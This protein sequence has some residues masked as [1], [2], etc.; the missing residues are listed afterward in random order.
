MGK[1]ENNNYQSQNSTIKIFFQILFML[2]MTVII[3]LFLGG[4][5]LALRSPDL[6]FGEKVFK[7]WKT[8]VIYSTLAILLTPIQIVTLYIKLYFTDLTLKAYPE[9]KMLLEKRARL[10]FELKS[11]VKLELGTESLYQ[12]IGQ[13]IFLL[14]AKTDTPTDL[15]SDTIRKIQSDSDLIELLVLSLIWSFATNILSN[16]QGLSTRRVFFPFLSQIMAGLYTLCLSTSR[17][18]AMVLYFTPVLGLFGLLKHYKAE[19]T[20]WDPWIERFFVKDNL[21]KVGNVTVKWT[22]GN[23]AINRS[24]TGFGYLKIKKYFCFLSKELKNFITVY[25]LF[26]ILISFNR[27]HFYLSTDGMEMKHLP[28]NFILFIVLEH[29]L[30]P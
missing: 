16:N 6:I 23:D 19:Q 11:F 14:M 21:I 20:K 10:T 2:I 9:D 12:L 17:V 7:S 28:M 15:I 22:N 5:R 8:R 27:Y 3:P 13:F 18:L 1:F 30:K 29:I 4:I 24:V 26:K 25:S